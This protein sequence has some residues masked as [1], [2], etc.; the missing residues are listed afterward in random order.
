MNRRNF[1][2]K[3]GRGILLGG[4]AAVTGVLISRQQVSRYSEC[5]ADFQCKRCNRL[6]KC[7]L[8]EAEIERSNG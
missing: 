4:L 2:V 7:A 8:P 6:S 5:T 1:V 3:A